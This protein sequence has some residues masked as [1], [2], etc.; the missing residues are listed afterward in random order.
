MTRLFREGRTETVRS[1]TED[2]C[3]FVKAI[4]GGKPVSE[5]HMGFKKNVIYSYFLLGII[6]N[7]LPD[8]EA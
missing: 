2:T 3:N 6:Y 7:N 5:T 1:S 8:N 4:E